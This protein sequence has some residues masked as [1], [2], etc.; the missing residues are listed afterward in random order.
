MIVR[1]LAV[2]ALY[3]LASMRGALPH[4]EAGSLPSSAAA[5]CC[6]KG[7][8]GCKCGCNRPSN[9]DQRDPGKSRR[10]VCGCATNPVPLPQ[11]KTSCRLE[12]RKTSGLLAVQSDE[13]PASLRVIFPVSQR[14]HSPP[15]SERLLGTFVLLI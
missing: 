6:C 15:P 5:C 10:L 11:S 13:L 14:A 12:P 9:K 2:L 7:K 1:S 3:L 4:N 8:A